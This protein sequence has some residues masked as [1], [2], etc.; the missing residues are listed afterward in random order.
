MRLNPVDVGDVW[1]GVQVT[2]EELVE[3]CV[4]F[5]SEALSWDACMLIF[6]L[7]SRRKN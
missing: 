4:K 2:D 5:E 1:G 7:Y 6:I 3:G